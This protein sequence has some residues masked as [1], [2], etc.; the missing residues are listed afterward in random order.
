MI[1]ITY[2]VN[3]LLCLTL[4]IACFSTMKTWKQL[5]ILLTSH[6]ENKRKRKK[7]GTHQS[8]PGMLLLTIL[9]ALKKNEMWICFILYLRL[10]SVWK[11][12]K[13]D[14]LWR[15]KSD[16]NHDGILKI[17]LKTTFWLWYFFF[18]VVRK[19]GEE[20]FTLLSVIFHTFQCCPPDCD[21]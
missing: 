9:I 2:M 17:T 14:F 4:K 20:E 21:N 6:F 11:E 15:E 19:E 10:A 5:G 18:Q 12:K 1:F 3:F 13:K 7:G 16:K 8:Q